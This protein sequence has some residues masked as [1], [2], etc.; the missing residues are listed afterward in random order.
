MSARN[1]GQVY[2]EAE[3]GS[4]LRRYIVDLFVYIL[5]RRGTLEIAQG[6]REVKK[7]CKELSDD[8]D[9][10][11]AEMEGKKVGDPRIGIACCYHCHWPN[12]EC[13]Y[14]NPEPF[15]PEKREG[16]EEKLE[17]RTEQTSGGECQESP[18]K[19]SE[20]RPESVQPSLQITPAQLERDESDEEK[21]NEKTLLTV[22]GL[23][24]LAAPIEDLAIA[25]DTQNLL[26]ITQN[27]DIEPVKPA[28]LVEDP[29]LAA[30]VESLLHDNTED[31]NVTPTRPPEIV[32]DPE[33]I[34]KTQDKLHVDEKEGQESMRLVAMVEGLDVVA[35]MLDI[36]HSPKDE[37]STSPQAVTIGV[38]NSYNPEEEPPSM[39][40]NT[41]EIDAEEQDS[42]S[43][44]ASVLWK[45]G[46][47]LFRGMD[48]VVVKLS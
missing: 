3:K 6:Y 15:I 46:S 20:Q 25:A 10:R 9:A 19:E 38:V 37:R 27:E 2:G 31:D 18:R 22:V 43:P 41:D 39:L 47:I 5:V 16:Q 48:G 33:S 36:L 42:V 30:Q 14:P 1:C 21:S 45:P 28:R 24:E 13:S 44:D 7:R 35:G 17:K 34:A 8:V 23:I 12:R 29:A 40:P 32:E 4:G 11:T 26:H